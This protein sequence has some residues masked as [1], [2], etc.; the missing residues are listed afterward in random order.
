[1][2]PLVA[3]KT[4][5]AMADHWSARAHR[6][7]G[8]ASH[9]RHRAEWKRVLA[10]A[11]GERSLDVVDLGAGTGACALIAAELGHRVTA[12]DGSEGMLA[13]ARASAAERGLSVRFVKAT[14]DEAGLAEASADAV[15]LRNVL[16]TL[17]NPCAALALAWRILRPGGT[18]LV[19]DGM[20]R[21]PGQE[22]E[23]VEIFGVE[24]P[25]Y[26]GLTEA[27][28]RALLRD[29]GFLDPKP[30]HGLFSVNPYDAYGEIPFFLLT[31][32]KPA[33]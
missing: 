28:A 33:G 12:I 21:K 11:L 25:F 22:R 17:E 8:A 31:A 7:D 5:Q 19:S 10:A 20:W 15:T 16:W 9:I 18:L 2:M 32:T 1:M 29:A 24:L 26:N 13:H 23:A 3:P 14:M 6:F 30:W 4:A 27:D